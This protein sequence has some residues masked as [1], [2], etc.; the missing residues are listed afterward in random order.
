MRELYQSNIK[1]LCLMLI[2]AFVLFGS[3]ALCGSQCCSFKH[4]SSL[5]ISLWNRI[6]LVAFRFFNRWLLSHDQSTIIAKFFVILNSA[7]VGEITTNL[8]I[9][10]V[11]SLIFSSK[12]ILSKQD[13]LMKVSIVLAM[14]IYGM[15]G[16]MLLTKLS[17]DFVCPKRPSPAVVFRFSTIHLEQKATSVHSNSYT[18]DRLFDEAKKRDLVKEIA[19]DSWPGEHTA[20]NFI[21]SLFMSFIIHRSN[22][23]SYSPTYIFMHIL[24]W[25]VSS[26]F[27]IA[28]LVS[29]AHWLSDCIAGGLTEA[30][31]IV[32]FGVYTPIFQLLTNSI[33]WL[34][35]RLKLNKTKKLL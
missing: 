6:D 24:V 12:S 3:W 8:I 11:T 16:Q 14:I 20:V 9:I 30:L 32:A 18:I 19:Y 22:T 35:N 26:L 17:R 23:S 29:G 7:G 31:V 27:S 5:K 13:R 21:W 34:M 15:S 28:R 1:R 10:L 25:F 2:A 4:D 33:Y